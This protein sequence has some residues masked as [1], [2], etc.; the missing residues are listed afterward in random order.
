M[1]VNANQNFLPGGFKVK[2]NI[3]FNATGRGVLSGAEIMPVQ[4]V[5][6]TTVLAPVNMRPE[7]NVS[8]MPTNPNL[9]SSP[10]QAPTQAG[11]SVTP[12]PSSL[13]GNNSRPTID[14]SLLSNSNSTLPNPAGESASS[15]MS[16][17][18]GAM[19]IIAVGLL[20]IAVGYGAYKL[21]KRR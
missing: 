13:P 1:F 14:P 2:S 16:G 15:V 10:N 21:L 8:L 12:N 7:L 9:T 19:P 6:P 20:V 3:Y 17:G 5:T 4:D 18:P 11:P